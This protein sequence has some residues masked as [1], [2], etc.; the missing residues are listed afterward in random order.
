M[1]IPVLPIFSWHKA[2][3]TP[4]SKVIPNLIFF[5]SFANI[6]NPIPWSNSCN[7]KY[8]IIVNKI[9]VRAV[10]PITSTLKINNITIG[11]INITNDNILAA[12]IFNSYL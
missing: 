8:T 11:I 9:V 5:I 6:K 10:H 7:I 1:R 3:K 2:Y 4:F 12:V